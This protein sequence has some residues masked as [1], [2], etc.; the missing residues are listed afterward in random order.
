MGDDLKSKEINFYKPKKRFIIPIESFHIPKSLFKEYKKNKYKFLINS[1]FSKVIETCSN[2]KRKDKDTWINNTI[3]TEY[4]NL[5]NQGFAKSIECIKDGKIV[6]GLYGVHLGSCF[7]G[8]SMF[9]T[10]SNTSKLCLMYLI[11]ILKEYNFS[12]LDS[13]FFNPHLVQFGAYEILDKDYQQKLKNGI[14]NKK[15]FPSS[16]NNQ[17][18]IFILQ[19]LIDKS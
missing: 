12:L 18:S 7:F 8:E 9:S 3:K 17:K 6:A 15:K 16:F 1:N 11:S 5:H 19:S 13:Q 10:I 2:I 4:I 14:K